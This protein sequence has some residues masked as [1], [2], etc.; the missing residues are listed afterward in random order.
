[1][2]KK[3]KNWGNREWGNL[4]MVLGLLVLV[5]MFAGT[6]LFATIGLDTPLVSLKAGG[7]SENNAIGLFIG[8]GLI[9]I[10]AFLRF[11]K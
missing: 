2:A 5:V 9:I 3:I 7:I 6:Q 1:M 11:K 4:L 8:F 10:G